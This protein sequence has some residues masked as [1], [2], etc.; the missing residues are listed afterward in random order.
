MPKFKPKNEDEFESEIL[1]IKRV[2]RVTAGGKRF[3]F[4]AIVVTGDKN[5][6][7]G[8]GI[9]KSDDVSK[10]IEKANQQARKHLIKISL[11]ESRTIPFEVKKKYKA[12]EVLL[13]PAAKGKG[14]VAGGVV[15]IICRLAGISDITAKSLGSK[16]KLSKARAT[17]L[18]LSEFSK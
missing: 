7:V 16:N 2:T 11:F 5:G 1:E 10:S 4:K 8:L 18:T 14:I 15:R 17:L 6:S 12:S 13:K 9:G 3:R